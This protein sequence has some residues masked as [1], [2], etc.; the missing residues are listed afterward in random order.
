MKEKAI[1][2]IAYNRPE[3]LKAQLNQLKTIRKSFDYDILAFID[4]PK[5]NAELNVSNE[6]SNII[7]SN[8]DLFN[9]IEI[10]DKNI[11]L[12]ENIKKAILYV[13]KKYK[14]FIILED[15]ISIEK[16]T[17]EFADK[18]LDLYEADD[19]VV[20]INLW[21][22][23]FINENIHYF[24]SDMHCWGWASWSKYWSEDVFEVNNYKDMSLINKIKLSNYF[25][26]NHYLHLYAN[27]KKKRTTWAVLWMSYIIL[28]NKKCISPNSSLAFNL[29]INSGTH[30]DY[31]T[32]QKKIN[33]SDKEINNLV[34]SKKIILKTWL[35]NIL[36]TN[37]ILLLKNIFCV[38]FK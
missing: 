4:G 38:L 24:T 19:S 5:D 22:Y 9:F 35:E 26:T 23:S 27:L 15:D 30:L 33:K 25:S 31:I 18:Y 37:K 2:I 13:T 14:K 11:G 3:L 10:N 7:K 6:M 32:I 1:A 8:V 16:N 36:L 20:H 17:I 21:N 12:K 34:Y 29:G 28:N